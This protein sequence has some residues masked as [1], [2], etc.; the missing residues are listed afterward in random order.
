MQIM[1]KLNKFLL[2]VLVVFLLV[3]L[4]SC[5]YKRGKKIHMNKDAV[6]GEW[7]FTSYSLAFKDDTAWNSDSK[8]V[9]YRITPNIEEDY[10]GHAVFN[11]LRISTH[12]LLGCFSD[13]TFIEF[14]F[15]NGKKLRLLPQSADCSVEVTFNLSV[16]DR[17]LLQ[18]Y[19][20]KSILYNHSAD[21]R[22]STRDWLTDYDK[23]FF[24]NLFSTVDEIN[25]VVWSVHW[26]SIGY[27]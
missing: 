12:G 24:S 14:L 2:G 22:I 23:V 11:K 26:F 7:F 17:K 21:E 19:V 9:F 20:I 25:N 3:L 8:L 18:G 27:D 13:D 5:N 10:T 6:T 4:S 16:E 15:T 1:D